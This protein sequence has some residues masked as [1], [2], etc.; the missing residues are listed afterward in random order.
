M[1]IQLDNITSL[2]KTMKH[3]Y[4]P[5]FFDKKL[6]GVGKKSGV[7]CETRNPNYVLQQNAHI[8]HSNFTNVIITRKKTYR[9]GPCTI[10]QIPLSLLPDDAIVDA[11]DLS[12]QLYIQSKNYSSPS[13]LA[14]TET[15]DV[16]SLHEIGKIDGTNTKVFVNMLPEAL[17]LEE[18]EQPAG[19][20]EVNLD[21]QYRPLLYCIDD[22]KTNDMITA[23]ES[24]MITSI[25]SYNSFNLR[26]VC[27]KTINPY[28]DFSQN[29]KDIQTVFSHGGLNMTINVAQFDTFF[30]NYDLYTGICYESELWNTKADSIISQ[31]LEVL[32]KA[33]NIGI[34]KYTT[35][36]ISEGLNYLENY[37]VPLEL[38]KNIYKSLQQYF[39]NDCT[40]LCK[41]NLNLMLSDR[42]YNLNKQKPQL[43]RLSPQPNAQ[44]AML[45]SF[46]PEQQGAITSQEPLI[47]VQAGAGTGKT[48]TIMGR[49]DYMIACGVQPSDIT[50][51]SF[52][53]AAADN[54]TA[55][56][57][58]VNSMTIARMIHSIYELNFTHELSSLDTI[59]NAIDIYFP[60]K[61][62]QNPLTNV[63]QKFKTVLRDVIKDTNRFTSLNNFVEENYD[64][65]MKI[66][67]TIN[68]TSLELEIIICYQKIDTLKEPTST[69]CKF[70]IIDEVQD[71]SI[72]EF[73]YTLKYVSKHNISLFIVGDCSQ[74]L[75]EFRASN[76]K[77]LNILE[78]S[79]VFDTHKL[80]IN[81][82]SNQEIL[83]FANVM[84]NN[85]EA[86]Q[87]AQ[88]QLHANSLT[89][90]TAQSFAD[91]VKF[92][93]QCLPKISEAKDM[94][95]I[96]FHTSVKNYID[97]KLSKNET[98]A[99]LAFTRDM[100]NTIEAV[101]HETEPNAIVASLVPK[102]IYNSTIF[103]AFVKTFW[104]DATK[105][106]PTGHIIDII[107]HDIM[108]HLSSLVLNPDKTTV[109]VQR[110]LDKWK[111]ENTVIIQNWEQAY[112][113][114]SINKQ[115]FLDLIKDN[116][117]QF[118]IKENAVKQSLIA[119][120]NS[121]NKQQNAVS[122]A[123]ILLSTIHSAKGLEFDN[124]IILY[125]NENNLSEDKKRMYYVA[126][127]R[128]MKSEY[129]LAYDTTKCPKI[130]T[131]YNDIVNRLSG[132][133]T[134]VATKIM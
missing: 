117:I 78:G 2:T 38:Y 35:V 109:I 50:I 84:L 102:K 48:H 44:P 15:P 64:D 21:V 95:R 33:N 17:V 115:K 49:I 6:T 88:I 96:A 4:T 18:I 42:L 89:P 121:K 8:Q 65:V 106:A 9:N 76:P 28:R 98:V 70:L 118:E 111:K 92:E 57:P 104:Y 32:N 112:Y 30:N 100:L 81:Y 73:I 29:I 5:K 122:N 54:V 97:K 52:T 60:K 94:V 12:T 90:I 53:N 114:G 75:Y 59:V 87:Y 74:T 26:I 120:E 10:T 25:A 24:R 123:N 22:T 14:T 3:V 101:L 133:Q 66:L 69:A 19:P 113:A 93:Y 36:R 61:N 108:S 13:C 1:P 46:S 107:A 55:R 86:N 110:M 37:Q 79:G 62:R 27:D 68:Q 58:K 116:L 47:L 77:A 7:L 85:I 63:A 124:V 132:K 125:R 130:E 119:A 129:V 126:L 82:R 83:D 80:Q 99:I 134:P 20:K 128:A 16:Q 23:Y 11:A 127:T 131:D 105:F 56:N 34:L 40:V 72:F 51:L 91:K 39:P 43:V 31:W 67:D 41:Q 71:N 45:Q 103:S